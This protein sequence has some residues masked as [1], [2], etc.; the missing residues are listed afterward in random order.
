MGPLCP[1]HSSQKFLQNLKDVSGK[2]EGI[3]SST[4]GGR[5]VFMGR[6]GSVFWRLPVRFAPHR[7]LRRLASASAAR[8][9]THAPWTRPG[10]WWPAGSP[11][12]DGMDTVTRASGRT[13]P[14]ARWTRPAPPAVRR[15]RMIRA[16]LYQLIARAR[17]FPERAQLR[18]D[19]MSVPSQSARTCPR[20]TISLRSF[21][22]AL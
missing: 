18:S 11:A 10:H 1:F 20:K 9:G 22:C 8:P 16:G 14:R 21:P 17:C 12:H 19:T 2:D 6:V 4:A 5:S 13:P 7:W 3:Y 15:Q